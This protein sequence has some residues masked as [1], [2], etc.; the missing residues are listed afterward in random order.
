MKPLSTP[1][2]VLV[3]AISL[4]SGGS[5][6]AT[7]FG[8]AARAGCAAA[9]GTAAVA[10]PRF[11]RT[12]ATGET[13]WFASPGLVDLN[14]DGSLEI[15]APFYST[16]VFDA[17]G[18]SARQGDGD[19]GSRLR[20]RSR[21]RPRRRQGARDRRRRQRGNRRGVRAP[22]RAPEAGARLARVDVQRRPVSRGAG[23]GGRRPRRR[24]PHRSRRHDDEHLA[25]RIAGLRVRREGL[26][27]PAEG[28]SG[29]RVA[30]V[31]H[32]V[33]Q[34]Q[35]RR[36]QRLPATTA[37]APTARTSASATSTT[38]RSSR[39]LS[40]S[41]TTRSTSSTTTGRRCSHPPGS[42]IATAA[43]A[44]AGSAGGSSSAG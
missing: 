38:T 16:F 14:G 15:V 23:H 20:T 29:D 4:A 5:S 35:R 32:A 41:T 42:G 18:S 26:R 40:L 25:D 21:C 43:T 17:E 19:E 37:T 27:L 12:I 36:L 28:R 1:V 9:N 22:R 34:G 33:R 39:S 13:G 44:G 10:A 8:A 24:R 31:Q 30:A 11:V 3:A 6:S 2:A 7:D